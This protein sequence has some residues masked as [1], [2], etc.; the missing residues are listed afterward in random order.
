[1]AT[2]KQLCEVQDQLQGKVSA[3]SQFQQLKKMV[4]TKN[5]QLREVRAKLKDFEQSN[6]PQI[7]DED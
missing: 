1:L 5:K 6:A 3:S 7:N 2:Q 4:Q